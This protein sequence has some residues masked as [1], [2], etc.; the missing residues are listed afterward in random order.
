[1]R[2]KLKPAF[3]GMT[4]LKAEHNMPGPQQREELI[5]IAELY[6]SGQIN[7]PPVL[8]PGPSLLNSDNNASGKPNDDGVFRH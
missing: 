8:H 5:R 7:P 1:M 4:E 6:T 3:P 2:P